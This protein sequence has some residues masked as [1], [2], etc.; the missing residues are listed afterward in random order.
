M[1]DRP[2]TRRYDTPIA[3]DRLPYATAPMLT[4]EDMKNQKA[5]VR[6]SSLLFI[7]NLNLQC[8]IVPRY[9]E[10]RRRHR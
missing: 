9:L 7:Y 2:A 5:R 10:R 6:L 3:W 8:M 4:T 1:G